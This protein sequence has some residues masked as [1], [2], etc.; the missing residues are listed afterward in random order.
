MKEAETDAM[1][2]AAITFGD[3]FGLA[4]Y[5]KSQSHVDYDEAPA[6][7]QAAPRQAARAD[8]NTNQRPPKRTDQVAAALRAKQGDKPGPHNLKGW[9]AYARDIQMEDADRRLIEDLSKTNKL[10]LTA[11]ATQAQ[12]N[13]LADPKA[14]LDLAN[15]MAAG[16]AA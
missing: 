10:K 14:V 1:K 6:P 5:D 8:V 7:R 11:L 15:T 9:G 16:A 4:L 3:R 13:G 2:R 12:M